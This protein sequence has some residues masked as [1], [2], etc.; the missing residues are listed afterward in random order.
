MIY[1]EEKDF[2]LEYIYGNYFQHL[3]EEENVEAEKDVDNSVL[4]ELMEKENKVNAH[5]LC[6]RSHWDPIIELII[7]VVVWCR[8]YSKKNGQWGI[9]SPSKLWK[10]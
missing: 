5:I 2:F 8:G 10:I 6:G 4:W 3:E 1:G 7:F 9:Y